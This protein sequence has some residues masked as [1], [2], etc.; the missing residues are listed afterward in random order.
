VHWLLHA[1]TV[2]ISCAYWRF[3]WYTSYGISLSMLSARN[4][5]SSRATVYVLGHSETTPFLLVNSFDPYTNVGWFALAWNIACTDCV[6]ESGVARPPAGDRGCCFLLLFSSALIPGQVCGFTCMIHAFYNY[7]LVFSIQV[8]LMSYRY[9][10]VVVIYSFET[11]TQMHS[12]LITHYPG[13]LFVS[14]LF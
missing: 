6:I 4:F 8:I 7:F 2:Y 9:C 3:L 1:F 13:L 14:S 12:C 10:A 11:H 5:P